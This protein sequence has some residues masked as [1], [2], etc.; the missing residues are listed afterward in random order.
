M[1][2]TTR[3]GTTRAARTEG[4]ARTVPFVGNLPAEGAR[5]PGFAAFWLLRMGFTVAPILFGV[6][7]FFNWMVEW[8]QYLW[9]GAADFLPGTAQQIMYGVGVVEIL[10]GV[11]V[12]L[13]P[14][15]GSLLVAAWLGA[16][17][18]NLVIQAVDDPGPEYWDIALR[19]FGLMTGALALFLLATKYGPLASRH[20]REVLGTEGGDGERRPA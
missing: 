5:D 7:K 13:T 4:R 14:R 3:E 8:P 10:A 1:A 16:I 6:D 17:V 20:Q 12:L 19:D 11:I 15:I 2:A 9:S 18:G